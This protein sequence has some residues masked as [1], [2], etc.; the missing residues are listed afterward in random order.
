MLPHALAGAAIAVKVGNPF[1]VLPLAFLSH[2]ILDIFPHWNPHL[3]TEKTRDGKVSK[4]S[5][6]IC[7]LDS[8]TAL[9]VGSYIAFS[10]WPNLSMVALVFTTCFFAV[11]ADLIEAPFFFLGWK[12]KYITKFILFQRK[13]QWNVSPI[14]GILSQA[15]FVSLALY[16]IFFT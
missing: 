16:L 13:I 8:G 5:T 15:T 7:F 10:F 6:T 12:N 3:Y 9:V 1:L 2:F 14:P 4:S 11:S